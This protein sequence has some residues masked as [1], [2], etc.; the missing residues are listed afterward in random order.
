LGTMAPEG[1][2]ELDGIRKLV[3]EAFAIE[4]EGEGLKPLF[5]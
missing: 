1:K 4:D 5:V 3:L 2:E